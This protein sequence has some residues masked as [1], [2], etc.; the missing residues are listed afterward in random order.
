MQLSLPPQEVKSS[1]R[2]V[3]ESLTAVKKMHRLDHVPM[4][5][6][7]AGMGSAIRAGIGPNKLEAY[8]HAGLMSEVCR[9]TKVPEYLA[10]LYADPNAR[11][12]Y[13]LALLEGLDGVETETTVR[14]KRSA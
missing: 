5:M 11:T 1:H 13:A 3:D 2:D 14:I 9:G 4:D 7:K 10:K 8:G 6:A 12:R